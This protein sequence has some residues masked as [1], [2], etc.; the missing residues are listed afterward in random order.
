MAYNQLVSKI[1]PGEKTMKLAEYYKSEYVS[2]SEFKEGQ[3]F[4]REIAEIELKEFT[5]QRTQKKEKKAVLYFKAIPN[6]VKRRGIILNKTLVDTLTGYFGTDESDDWIGK[7]ITITTRP[8]KVY[9]EDT[10]VF[11]FN[12]YVK[13]APA[14][15]QPASSTPPAENK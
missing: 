8:M 7:T 3:S 6:Q 4:N 5:D 11:V 10:R 14:P 2:P 15:E 13:P 1:C 9:G 12:R